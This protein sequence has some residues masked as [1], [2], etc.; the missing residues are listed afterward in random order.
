MLRRAGLLTLHTE[1]LINNRGDVSLTQH[2]FAF[3]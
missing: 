2:W 1:M 3:V